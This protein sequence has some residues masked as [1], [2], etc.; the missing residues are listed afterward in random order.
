MLQA[1]DRTPVVENAWLPAQP[2]EKSVGDPI[3]SADSATVALQVA[4][5]IVL[6]DI[7][8]LRA[9]DASIPL[10]PGA[11]LTVAD[12]AKEGWLAGSTTRYAFDASPQSWLA[13]ACRLAG[14]PMAEDTWRGYLGD[15]RPFAPACRIP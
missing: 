14:G 12:A 1:A 6:F 2:G 11:G 8:S 7:A 4:E 3:F 10:P 13:A 9:L 15:N 5:R